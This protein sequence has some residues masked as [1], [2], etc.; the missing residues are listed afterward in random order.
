MRRRHV[1]LAPLW[2]AAAPA[3]AELAKKPRRIGTLGNLTPADS[4]ARVIYEQFYAGLREHGWIEGETLA[5]EA[6][7]ADERPERYPQLADEL[8]ALGL[9]AIVAF[10]GSQPTQLLKERTKTIPIVMV[11]VS[12]PVEAGFVPR[13]V[14]PAA[15]S[16]A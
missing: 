6:R 3:L 1:L 7:W 8:V 9:E 16:P 4:A 2:I 11:A 15:T 12:H 5:V 10:G 14:G 13:W